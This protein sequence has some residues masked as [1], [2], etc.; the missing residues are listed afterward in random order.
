M[1][2]RYL[3][4]VASPEDSRLAETSIMGLVQKLPVKFLSLT[5]SAPENFLWNIEKDSEVRFFVDNEKAFLFTTRTSCDYSVS[6]VEL[7]QQY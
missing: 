4:E 3:N 1:H 6:P 7:R 2:L 5:V